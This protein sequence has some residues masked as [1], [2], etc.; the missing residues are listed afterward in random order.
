M[1]TKTSTPVKKPAVKKAAPAPEPE[2]EVEEGSWQETVVKSSKLLVRGKKATAQSGSM[3]WAGAQEGILDWLDS[4]ADEDVNGEAFYNEL[5]TLLGTSRRGDAS[6]IKTVAL[7][8][9]DHGLTL[10]SHQ[11]VTKAY[12]EAKRLL[13]VAPQNTKDDETAEAMLAAI[14]APKSTSKPEG[15]ATILIAKGVD[16]ATRLVVDA[17]I[18]AAGGSYDEAEPV[19]RAFLRTFSQEVAGRKPKPEPK[20]AKVKVVA[21]SKAKAAPKSGAAKGKANPKVARQTVAEAEAEIEAEQEDLDLDEGVEYPDSPDE[22]DD[23]FDEIEADEDDDDAVS[24]DVTPEVPVKRAVGAKPK[25]RPVV[26]RG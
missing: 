21:E 14:V 20:P 23:M 8:V 1:A 22:V 10:A 6:K 15:A 11:S 3:L 18:E 25:A 24:P 13:V 16:E 9:K 26:R 7:A 4:Q 19:L 5:L 2:V 12:G 17:I